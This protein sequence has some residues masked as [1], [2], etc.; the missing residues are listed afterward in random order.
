MPVI[1][2]LAS[3]KKIP[4]TFPVSAWAQS[5]HGR[6]FILGSQVGVF[7]LQ[8]QLT[9]Q[10]TMTHIKSHAQNLGN[11]C[12]DHAAAL[13]TFGLGSNQNVCTRWAHPSFDSNSLFALCHNLGDVFQVML[14]QHAYLLPK[15]SSEV[16]VLFHTVSL[17]GLSRFRL[18][19]LGEWLFS[20]LAQSMHT[21]SAA[22][23]LV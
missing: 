22:K 23:S 11:E 10:L 1:H 6:T 21:P 15:A 8:I 5:N 20:R 2:A 19:F 12:V 7:L 17:R 18:G 13:G 4:S 16:D 3:F 14:E 9:L